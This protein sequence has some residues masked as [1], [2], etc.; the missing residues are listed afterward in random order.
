M[1]EAD[2]RL[3]CWYFQRRMALRVRLQQELVGIAAVKPTA[4]DCMLVPPVP[5]D[6]P[7]DRLIPSLSVSLSLCLSVC[8]QWPN[9]TG[10]DRGL[11]LHSGNGPDRFKGVMFDGVLES[12]RES[13]AVV[14]LHAQYAAIQPPCMLNTFR[15][16]IRA[17]Q[18][19]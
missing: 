1:Y 5:P 11:R 3:P 2:T 6:V 19:L 12:R 9:R 15:S 4:S 16:L 8:Y 13:F 10:I 14:A 7:P 18:G 17:G